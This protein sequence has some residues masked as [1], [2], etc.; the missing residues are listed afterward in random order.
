M[1]FL[2]TLPAKL[3]LLALRL[4]GS[5]LARTFIRSPFGESVFLKAYFL[6]KWLYE[7]RQ[8]Q[9]L[10]PFTKNNS[11]IV[12][13]GA[14]IGFFTV[15]FARW[16]DSGKVL[17]LEPEPDNFRRLQGVIA[18]KALGG[19]VEARQ[20]AAAE[21][22]GTGHLVVSQES[23]ADHRLGDEGM[24]IKLDTLDSIWT[25]FGCPDVR[26]I[27]IDVQGVEYEVLLGAVELLKTCRP[28]LYIEIDAT[29]ARTPVDRTQ[30][31]LRMMETQGYQPNIWRGRWNPLT[32]GQVVPEA[33]KN[34]TGYA[35]FLFL[36][37]QP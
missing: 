32:I 18:G 26:L 13:V 29:P 2:R 10:R 30:S 35:D 5:A 36:P 37:D 17:A 21:R 6:Y 24:P 4:Y 22:K 3:Q 12:D 34:A 19:R 15:I 1:T 25:E 31:L 20:V 11:W 14:N 7:A 27:K 28:A 8:I 16:L 33:E 9:Q 23:H